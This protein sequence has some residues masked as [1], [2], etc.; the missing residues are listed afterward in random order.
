L[1]RAIRAGKLPAFETMT[2]DSD[3][4]FYTVQHRDT[5]RPATS[6][7]TAGEGPPPPLLRS[8][9]GAGP[10]DPTGYKTL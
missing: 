3:A 7:S 10:A 8:V 2:G 6:S 9:L 1:K 5:R 4:A